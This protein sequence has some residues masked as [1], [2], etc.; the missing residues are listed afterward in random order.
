MMANRHQHKKDNI[1]Q[2]YDDRGTPEARQA[3]TRSPPSQLP[4][5]FAYGG[6]AFGVRGVT[7][8]APGPLQGWLQPELVSEERAYMYARYD[9]IHCKIH[10]YVGA[11]LL[12]LDVE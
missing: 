12:H 7:K 9:R 3:E 2:P 4:F 6:A 10:I 8:K 1:E 11:D 5:S